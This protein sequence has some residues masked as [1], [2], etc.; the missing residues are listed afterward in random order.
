MDKHD[1]IAVIKNEL[2]KQSTPHRNYGS[3]RPFGP[4]WEFR[5]YFGPED[6]AHSY[7]VG[8]LPDDE[9]EYAD[10][11]EL[12]ELVRHLCKDMRHSHIRH[13]MKWDKDES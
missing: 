11:R 6:K 7:C 1:A 8:G 2:Q 3:L 13:E 5:C 4:V 9:I 10:E 12:R